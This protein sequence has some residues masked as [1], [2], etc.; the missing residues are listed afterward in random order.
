MSSDVSQAVSVCTALEKLSITLNTDKHIN[1]VTQA[2]FEILSEEFNV[3]TA[4]M[5]AANPVQFNHVYEPQHI[6]EPNMQ[7]WQNELRGRG[8]NRVATWDWRASKL[9]VDPTLTSTGEERFPSDF[10]TSRLNKIHVFV[11]KAPVMEYGVKV[12]VRPKLTTT[13]VLVYP[14]GAIGPDRSSAS[15]AVVFT[16]NFYQFTPGKYTQGA[17]TAWFS[18]WWGGEAAAAALRDAFEDQRDDAFKASFITRT[19]AVTGRPA[20]KTATIGVDTA[21]AA[22]GQTIAD[23]ITGDLERNYLRMAARRRARNV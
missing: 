8:R 5:A 15:D 16:P 10:D 12:T 19:R 4:V 17:F 11:W 18:T 1:F 13:R 9:I 23:L 6:G 7:L 3:Q 2:A 22:R 20:L 21:A 14:L